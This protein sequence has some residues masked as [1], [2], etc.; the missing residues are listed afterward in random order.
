MCLSWLFGDSFEE[1]GDRLIREPTA[2]RVP[3]ARQERKW[4]PLLDAFLAG[5]VEQTVKLTRTGARGRIFQQLVERSL[6]ELG[7]EYRREPLFPAIEPD[8][9]YVRMASRFEL[10]LERDSDCNPDFLL[11]D[12]TWLEVTLSE[13]TA[14]RKLFRH[15]HQAPFLAVLWLDAD[16]GLH[17]QVCRDIA[18]PHARVSPI[19]ILRERLECTLRGRELTRQFEA[20]KRL[21]GI[22]G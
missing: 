22:L 18:F 4:R 10:K 6:D 11:A 1:H 12:G 3:A 15:G 20:L 17:S 5:D 19:S 16:T 14:Y 7:V 2:L 21:K 9:F 13:N 8:E